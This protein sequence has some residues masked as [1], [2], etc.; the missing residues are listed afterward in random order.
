MGRQEPR[1]R[2]RAHHSCPRPA[3]HRGYVRKCIRMHRE[4]YKRLQPDSRKLVISATTRF[5]VASTLKS[6]LIFADRHRSSVLWPRG[7]RP[8]PDLLHSDR[9]PH[10]P[11]NDQIETD[12]QVLQVSPSSSG[13]RNAR[14]FHRHFLVPK[15]VARK[16]SKVFGLLR[17]AGGCQ[18]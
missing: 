12:Q 11:G 5:R 14:S 3:H 9:L 2:V 16:S 10:R 8:V 15:A 1:R 13:T 4:M 6:F 7:H 17:F 18:R